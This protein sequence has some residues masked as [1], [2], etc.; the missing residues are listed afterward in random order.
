MTLQ[1]ISVED[2]KINPFHLFDKQWALLSAGNES[3]FNGMTVSWGTI[4]ILWNKNV[5][6]VFIRPDRYTREFVEKHDRFTLS[7]YGE[8]YKKTLLLLGTKSGRDSAK[9]KESGLT[10]LFIDKTVSF[11]EAEMTI[12]AKKLYCQRMD[13][14]F[15]IDPTVKGHYPDKD[16]HFMYQGEILKIMKK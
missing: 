4:G 5:V 6:T 11:E 3:G 16:Y 8:E 2:F 10:P 7:F 15:V 13:E 12:I 14:K 9:M 1:E